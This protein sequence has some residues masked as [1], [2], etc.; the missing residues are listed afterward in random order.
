MW[1]C[2]DDIACASLVVVL[3]NVLYFDCLCGF[4]WT[5]CD[6]GMTSFLL[7][8]CV[9]GPP[10]TLLLLCYRSETVDGSRVRQVQSLKHTIQNYE[11]AMSVAESRQFRTIVPHP[12][13]GTTV[14]APLCHPLLRQRSY[15][16][17]SRHLFC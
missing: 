11:A 17:V 5:P 15:T 12:S 14:C 13:Y 10:L 16:L 1:L 9:S 6:V 2:A 3:E 4:H 7:F 8:S